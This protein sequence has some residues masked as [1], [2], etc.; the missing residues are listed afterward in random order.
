MFALRDAGGD[1]GEGKW[2]NSHCMMKNWKQRR[3]NGNS[4]DTTTG[5]SDNGAGLEE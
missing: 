1:L 3:T 5:I 4:G 2:I